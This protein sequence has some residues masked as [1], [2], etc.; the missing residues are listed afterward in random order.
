MPTPRSASPHSL[1]TYVNYPPTEYLE[2]DCFDVCAFN[3]YL[4][5]EADLRA[6]LARLQ[7]IAGVAAAAACGGRRRQ[8][9][10]GRPTGRPRS[11]RCTSARRSRKGSAARWRSRGPT[12]GGV[13]AAR[14]RTGPSASSMRIARPKPALAAVSAAF[15]VGAVPGSDARRRGP[16]SRSSSAPTTPAD[17]LDDCLDVARAPQLSRLRG[18]RRQ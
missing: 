5:R 15:A 7:H 12:N 10:R 6:Y 8:H 17:T 14:S 1:L 9:P 4:H 13:A 2:L 18:H 3:V 11:P 16:R